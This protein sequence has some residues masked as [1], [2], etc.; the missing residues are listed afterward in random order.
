MKNNNLDQF[1]TNPKVCKELVNDFFNMF[2]SIKTNLN[3]YTFIEPSAGSGNFIDAILSYSYNNQSINKEQILGFDLEPKKNNMIIKTD[4]LKLNLNKYKLDKSKTIVIGNP[5]FG[6]KGKLALDFLNKCLK[7]SDIVLF[8]LPK[9]FKRYLL[10]KKIDTSAKL[11]YEKDLDSNS[12]L[13]DD[14]QYDVSCV[15]QIWVNK[16]VQKWSNL[17]DKRKQNQITNIFGDDL[18][19]FTHNNTK[20]TLKYFDKEKYGWDFAV[21]RQGYYDYNQKITNPKELKENRQYLFI[22]CSNRIKK[23][24]NKINFNKLANINNTTVKGFSNSD[25]YDELYQIIFNSNL[26]PVEEFLTIWDL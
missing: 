5:P 8:I 14:R 15:A 19:L 7:Y 21:V 20:E 3:Q 25:L 23:F 18:K 6:N 2:Y 11:I 4:F 13:V 10:Q 24:V 12:F 22:K 16:K 26:A 9:T 1:Y 17:I